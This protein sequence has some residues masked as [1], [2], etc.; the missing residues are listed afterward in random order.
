V[1]LTDE[2]RAT[3]ERVAAKHFAHL[4]QAFEGVDREELAN[5]EA[6]FRRFRQLINQASR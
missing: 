3:F 4:Q 5:I 6:G 2:G 1:N